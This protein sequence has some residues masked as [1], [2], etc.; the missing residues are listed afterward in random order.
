MTPTQK[1]WIKLIALVIG[2]GTASMAL[3]YNGGCV[4]WLSIVIG[5]GTGASNVYTALK[6]SPNDAK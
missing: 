6:D 2:T 3:A 1:A 4:L 5:I